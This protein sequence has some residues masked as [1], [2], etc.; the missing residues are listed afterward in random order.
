[1]K[2]YS[3]PLSMFGM[4][5][6]IACHEKG[7]EFELEMVP[8]DSNDRYRPK[9]PEVLRINPKGQVPVLIDG[10]AEL[11]DSTQ[12]FEYLED[13]YPEPA[14]WPSAVQARARARQLELMADEVYFPQVVRL[15]FVQ[16]RLDDDEARDARDLCAA[17][18][19]QMDALLDSRDWLASDYS[20]ADIALFMAALFAERMSAVLDDSTP[21][22]VE[23]RSRMMRREAVRRG[24]APLIRHLDAA[25]RP[26]PGFLR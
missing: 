8:F 26:V 20:Y 17:F 7:L 14:L 6:A 19:V 25:G 9:H 3:G 4:K 22:L 2:L 1:M 15:M 5:A 12:I 21:R 11:F 10:D 16:D 13:A 24:V 23:W 18:H